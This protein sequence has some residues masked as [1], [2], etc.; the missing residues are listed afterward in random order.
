M[1]PWRR[2]VA[3]PTTRCATTS[4]MPDVYVVTLWLRE[5]PSPRPS[6]EA[7]GLGAKRKAIPYQA[8]T[9]EP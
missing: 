1:R 9:I 2:V 6:P 3:A 8:P 4:G 7:R 5:Q